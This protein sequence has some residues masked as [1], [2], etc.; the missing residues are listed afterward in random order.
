MIVTG[1]FINATTKAVTTQAFSSPRLAAGWSF[2]AWDVTA[3]LLANAPAGASAVN[4]SLSMAALGAGW[5]EATI[6][7]G[8]MVEVANPEPYRQPPAKVPTGP[9]LYI[10]LPTVLA[11]VVI[12]LFGT[13]LWNRK[14][15]RIGLGNVM[16]RTRDGYGIGKSR[17]QRLGGRGR[18][19]QRSAAVSLRDVPPQQVYRDVPDD[20][21]GA[22][23]GEKGKGV[24]TR[25]M[26]YFDTGAASRSGDRR[27]SDA[28]GSLAGTPTSEHHRHHREDSYRA[29][30]YAQQYGQQ[31][32]HEHPQSGGR[33][34][35]A[36]RDEMS[37]QE[38]DRIARY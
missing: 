2:Y 1:N 32:G 23:N 31:Y 15:R 36:F 12:M 24:R 25:S 30:Q 20:N 34:G 29:Q 17:V 19:T 37:R 33:S 5:A 6:Y 13:C 27:D 10:A 11:F 38:R 9:A 22:H 35:N 8:P 21:D 18:T 16:S 4:I 7:P 28:L 14:K 26:L 3:A